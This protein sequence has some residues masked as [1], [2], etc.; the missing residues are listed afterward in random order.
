M[1]SLEAVENKLRQ[2]VCP[3]CLH[4][5]L[6]VTLQCTALDRDCSFIVECSTCHHR[7]QVDD[8]PETVYQ[9]YLQT[10]SRVF[11]SKCT[12]CGHSG[13]QLHFLCKLDSKKCFFVTECGHCKRWQRV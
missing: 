5:D 11:A 2:M 4:S 10:E 6:G 8:V 3:I 1:E 9:L 12:Y 13:G 7:F